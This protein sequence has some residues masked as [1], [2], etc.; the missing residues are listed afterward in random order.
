MRPSVNIRH[1]L[2]EARV[3]EWKRRTVVL[4]SSSVCLSPLSCESLQRDRAF[5]GHNNYY[6]FNRW[7]QSPT[8]FSWATEPAKDK[9]GP[10]WPVFNK[11]LK[12]CTLALP[13][14]R[15]SSDQRGW[16]FAGFGWRM[17]RTAAISASRSLVFA[18]LL[19]DPL[20]FQFGL[21]WTW[22]TLMI[23]LRNGGRLCG[24][25]FAKKLTPTSR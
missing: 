4:L 5:I 23:S 25:R 20:R 12:T 13:S 3:T 7:C 22:V 2:V 19:K 9:P 16:S 8:N 11:S 15:L 18:S 24:K 10:Q 14:W 21:L 1:S 6:P 17:R